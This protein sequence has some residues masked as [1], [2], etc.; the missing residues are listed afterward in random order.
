MDAFRL[1]CCGLVGSA[2]LFPLVGCKEPP[3]PPEVMRPVRAVRLNDVETFHSGYLPGRA[4]ATQEVNLAFRVSGPLIRFPVDVGTEVQHEDIVAEI[5]S[6]PFDYEVLRTQANLDEAKAE[7]EAMEAG[8][9]PEERDQ[10]QAAVDKA[11]ARRKAALSEFERAEDLVQSRTISQSDYERYEEAWKQAE[12]E[13]AQAQKDQDIGEAGARQE[14]IAAKN[15]QIKALEAALK[16]AEADVRYTKLRAPFT[17]T[18]VAKYVENYETVQAKQAIVRIVDTSRIEIVVNVPEGSISLV[19]RVT[20]ITCTFDALP[21]QPLPATVK[22]IGAEASRST[23]TY[24]VTLVMDQPEGVEILPG[25]TG[26]VRGRVQPETKDG[27]A[28]IEVPETA[29]FE[30]DDGKSYVWVI[31]TSDGKTGIA[32]RREVKVGK[33]MTR[34]L[35]IT[36]GVASQEI[37]ATAGVYEI[38]DGQQ[39]G[40]L[41]TPYE[42]AA[43]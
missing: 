20:D 6:D 40:V 10:L 5:D 9:R 2:L 36:S 15:A 25:M 7:L 8:A 18:V 22:E 14:D 16:L 26:R 31:E 39:V 34:G 38:K 43:Q 29:V 42:V 35:Q 41:L 32:H 33:L 13:L 12:A 23:R 11:T 3:P 24:P 27:E 28:A 1:V 30:G 4:K 17:G 21:D 19:P 37:V